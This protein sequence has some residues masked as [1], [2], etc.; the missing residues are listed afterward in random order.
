MARP[1]VFVSST[2]YDLKHIRSS[3]EIFINSLGYEPILSERGSIAYSPDAA[4]DE[5]CYREAAAADIFVLIIGG[6]YGAEV[7]DS[8]SLARKENSEAYDSITKREFDTAYKSDVPIYIAIETGVNAEYNTYLKNKETKGI[9]YAHVDNVNIFKFIDGVFAKK[10][11]NPV[12]SFDRSLQIEG[13]LRDQWSGLFKELLSRRNQNQKI[14]DL[15]DEIANLGSVSDTLKSYMQEILRAQDPQKSG[16]II[17]M[18]EELLGKNIAKNIAAHNPLA[19]F[20]KDHLKVS[21][22]DVISIISKLSLD[23]IVSHI[24]SLDGADVSGKIMILDI[25]T[26]IFA[27]DDLN[28]ARDTIGLPPIELT[29]DVKEK[30]HAAVRSMNDV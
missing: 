21:D 25:L 6:R 22:L 19:G 9:K 24:V 18:Q 16:E 1:R 17:A 3:L 26:N 2:Y 28:K 13:W 27:I 23:D 29:E 10:R 20:I 11:N 30:I 12:F 7:S 15:A 4:L 5:S 8:K 14:S